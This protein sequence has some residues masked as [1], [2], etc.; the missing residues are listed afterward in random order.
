[1]IGPLGFAVRNL[2]RRGFHSVLAFLGLTLTITST[3]FLLLLGETF[4][5]RLRIGF[6][7]SVSFGLKWLVTGYLMLSLV[8]V[9]IVGLLSASYLV[10]SMVNQR[11]RDIGVIKAA[12]ALPNRL[13]SYA[14]T[15]ALLVFASSCIVGGLVAGIIYASWA[16]SLQFDS[17]RTLIS[18]GVP[19][20]SFFLSYLAAR[21]QMLKIV[22]TDALSIVSSQ[23]SSLDLRSVGKPLRARRLGSSFNLAS[24][25]LS[26]DRQFMRTVVRVSI[27]IFLTMVVLSGALVSLDTSKSYLDRAMPS[28]VVIIGAAPMVNQYSLLAKSYSDPAP[29]P[30][31]DFLND[32]YIMTPELVDLFRT[33]PG[34]RG[35]DARL[36]DYDNVTGY[37]KAH[38]AN[39]G[40]LSGET[41][42]P[43]I[44]PQ[45]YTGAAAVLIVGV[46][47]ETIPDWVTSDGFL[48][49]TD[50]NF[51]MVSGDSLLG[52]LVREPFN[53]SRIDWLGRPFDVKSALVDPLNAG[54]VLYAPIQTLQNIIGTNGTNI[55]LVRT[56]GSQAALSTV[57]QLAAQNGLAYASQ[58]PLLSA[59]LA[60]LDN[61]WSYMFLLPI[62]TLALTCGILLSYLTTGFSKRFNDYVALRVLGAGP[63]YTL[64]VLFWEGFGT[65]GICTLIG[66]PAALVFSAIFLF[67]SASVQSFTLGLSAVASTIAIVSV[68][69]ASAVFY[70]R[71]LKMTTVKDL[72]L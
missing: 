15:E 37:V 21:R 43:E 26:R 8:F 39:S 56:D 46:T 1:M 49:N 52:G 34:V 17:A 18:L 59:N 2:R 42:S 10:S 65:V 68:G 20:L 61:V 66:L 62:L 29:L 25:T 72:K 67:P 55:L 27:C 41:S 5:V 50:S 70:S 23:L 45:V 7:T 6:S 24:R 64:G 63:R 19:G 11:L 9:L 32:S 38:F 28:D 51:T 31:I 40:D 48:R 58:A 16:G 3:T 30:R 14:F 47:N 13:F 60:Y 35:V 12:G 22:K 69:L 36:L 44:I 4:A 33:V 71:K 54:R 57:Q 53:Y